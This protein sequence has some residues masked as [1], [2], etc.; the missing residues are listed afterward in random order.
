MNI[1]QI[2]YFTLVIRKNISFNALRLHHKL[3]TSKDEMILSANAFATCYSFV[4]LEND[5]NKLVNIV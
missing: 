5:S 2:T 3:P 4:F 1:Y